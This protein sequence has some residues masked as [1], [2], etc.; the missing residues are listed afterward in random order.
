[1]CKLDETMIVA[2][3]NFSFDWMILSLPMHVG[4]SFQLS[5]PTCLTIFVFAIIAALSLCSC[6]GIVPDI[7]S[8]WNKAANI[9]ACP[10][11]K[12]CS[13]AFLSSCSDFLCIHL[14]LGNSH[15]HAGPISIQCCLFIFLLT[16]QQR[17]SRNKLPISLCSLV[18]LLAC[19]LLLLVSV[20]LSN[21][22][23]SFW[24]F[25]IWSPPVSS[26]QDP[27]T[28]VSPVALVVPFA[29]WRYRCVCVSEKS[30][31]LI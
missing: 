19:R 3:C 4:R 18:Q 6:E 10:F 23:F 14:S 25:S 26:A 11:L 22:S 15:S 28:S 21:V 29:P 12:L 13:L 16:F 1:M 30:W 8:V 31:L 24:S 7:T 20:W 9:D 17:F 5:M 27:S 2:L